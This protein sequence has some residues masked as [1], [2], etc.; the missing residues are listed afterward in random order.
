MRAKQKIVQGRGSSNINLGIF[1]CSFDVCRASWPVPSINY[2]SI[3]WRNLLLLESHYKSIYHIFFLLWH[4]WRKM[5]HSYQF[6]PSFPG[7]RDERPWE[8]GC[9]GIS[10]ISIIFSA[11]IR[12]INFSPLHCSFQWNWNHKW[13]GDLDKVLIIEKRCQVETLRKKILWAS[14]GSRTHALPDIGWTL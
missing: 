2:G 7:S 3:N 1:V 12:E 11:A 9:T 5:S 6:S 13:I 8:R 14:N 10:V 4:S